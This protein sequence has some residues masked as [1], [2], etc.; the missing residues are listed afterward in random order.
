VPYLRRSAKKKFKKM[1]CSLPSAS[2]EA[3]GKEIFKKKIFCSLPSARLEALG[4]EFFFKKK[5]VLLFAEC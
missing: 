1:V 4:K 2:L 3:L 5:I